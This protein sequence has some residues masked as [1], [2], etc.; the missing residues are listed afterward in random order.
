MM[1]VCTKKKKLNWVKK[2]LTAKMVRPYRASSHS[3][4]EILHHH[5]QEGVHRFYAMRSPV[6][7]R[8]SRL[9]NAYLTLFNQ[10]EVQNSKG[11]MDKLQRK[12]Q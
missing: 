4:H 8:G 2:V 12:K 9:S 7:F 6:N 11:S 3:L 5:Q 1:T 10:R